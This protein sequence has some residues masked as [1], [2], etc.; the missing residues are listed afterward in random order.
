MND[1]TFYT[2][3]PETLRDKPDNMA[4]MRH[5]MTYYRAQATRTGIEPL[6]RIHAPGTA[7]SCARLLNELTTASDLHTKTVRPAEA[8]NHER[9]AFVNRIR[10]AQ[11]YQWPGDFGTSTGMFDTLLAQPLPQYEDFLLQHAGKNAFDMGNYSRA[12]TYFEQ[13]LAIRKANARTDLIASTKMAVAAARNY[14]N[15]DN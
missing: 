14:L 11:V 1:D 9:A 4:D 5:T 8:E 3:N 13:A 2:I 7:G 12:L 6:S 10:L 15:E